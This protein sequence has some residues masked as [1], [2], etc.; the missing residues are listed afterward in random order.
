MADCDAADWF[1]LGAEAFS[2]A[3]TTT[4]RCAE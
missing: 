1:R 2:T 3:D 4:G